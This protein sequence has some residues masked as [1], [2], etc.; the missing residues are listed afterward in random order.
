MLENLILDGTYKPVERG[1]LVKRKNIRS[2]L[3]SV[4]LKSIP[5]GLPP[6]YELMVSTPKKIQNAA[7]CTVAVSCGYIIDD[8]IFNFP[9]TTEAFVQEGTGVVI[10]H[11]HILSSAHVF[12][13]PRQLGP[14]PANLKYK[15]LLASL[16][17]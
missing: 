2:L 10:D 3:G 12:D 14:P 16:T 7:L 15:Y 8:D 1:V 6:V 11:H 13:F 4:K 17:C 9:G 5:P